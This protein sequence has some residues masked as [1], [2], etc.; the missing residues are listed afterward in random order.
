MIAQTAAGEQFPKFLTESYQRQ[1]AT[2][3][4]NNRESL[5]DSVVCALRTSQLCP[6]LAERQFCG[7]IGAGK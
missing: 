2:P 6:P 4:V 7:V 1:E 5:Y 3:I